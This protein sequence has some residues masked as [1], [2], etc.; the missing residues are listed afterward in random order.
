MW[1]KRVAVCEY[2]FSCL[3]LEDKNPQVII[4]NFK[5]YNEYNALDIWQEQIVENFAINFL[6][7]ENLIKQHLK[8]KWTYEEFDN[9]TKAVI[10]EAIAE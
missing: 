5:N 3:L 1:A 9:L 8:T 4:E 7:Y 10:F 6:S 2:I